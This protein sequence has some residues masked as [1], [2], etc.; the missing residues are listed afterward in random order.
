MAYCFNVQ[1]MQSIIKVAT[2]IA[3]LEEQCGI[4][5]SIEDTLNELHF[6]LVEVVYEWA[7]G[8]VRKCSW[9]EVSGCLL[10][11]F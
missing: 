3:T 11:G 6:G 9:V 2:Q 5:H 1:G 7:C 8:K 4:N 10:F